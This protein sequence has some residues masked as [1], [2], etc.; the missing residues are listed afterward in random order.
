MVDGAEGGNAVN[1]NQNYLFHYYY[2]QIELKCSANSFS[3]FV[4]SSLEVGISSTN[5]KAAF[6]MILKNSVS[7]DTL[8]EKNTVSMLLA[9]HR[10]S[11]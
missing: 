11:M 7:L 10:V 2:C 9:F 4:S 8:K 3:Y 6:K 1:V 5:K